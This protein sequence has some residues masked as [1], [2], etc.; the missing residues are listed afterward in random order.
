MKDMTTP[1]HCHVPQLKVDAPAGGARRKETLVLAV[2]GLGCDNCANRVFN[3]LITTCGVYGAVVDRVTARVRVDFDPALTGPAAL[4]RSVESAG[5]R[6]GHRYRAALASHTADL[7]W[8][9]DG[10]YRK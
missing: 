7:S 3:S 1:R 5:E 8:P 10:G 2:A 6:S 4:V 9:A